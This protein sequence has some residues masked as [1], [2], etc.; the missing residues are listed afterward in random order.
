M[1]S[2]RVAIRSA[3]TL[4]VLG[5]DEAEQVDA[6]QAHRCAVPSVPK[7]E[8]VVAVAR[9]SGSSI[10]QCSHRRHCPRARGLPTRLLSKSL[11]D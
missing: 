2:E 6:Q 1:G 4:R 11:M 8:T 5:V 9:G 7:M 10:G 3:V